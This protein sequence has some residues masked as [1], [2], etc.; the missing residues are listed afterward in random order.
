MTGSGRF[1]TAFD[2][3]LQSG[4]RP[5]KG[6]I[7]ASSIESGNQAW[8]V[9]IDDA[10]NACILVTP[11]PSS[12]KRAPAIALEN[13]EV[14]YRVR[15]KLQHEVGSVETELYTLLR[16]KTEHE[17]DRAVFFSVCE[18]IAKLVGCEPD[19]TALNQAVI[20]LVALFRRLLLPPSRTNIGLF[21]EM[22]FILESR[23][24][25]RAIHAWRNDEYDRYDFSTDKVRIEVKSTSQSQ[26]IHEFSLE[27]CEVLPDVTGMVASV[28]VEPNAGGTTIQQLQSQIENQLTG[29]YSSLLKLRSVVAE[30]LH[31]G[32]NLRS[33]P[34]FDLKK[35]RHSLEIYDLNSIPAIREVPPRGVT[36]VRFKSNLDLCTP[37]RKT[38]LTSKELPGKS[39]LP[40]MR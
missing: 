13:L 39:I 37:L 3:L 17:S 25:G 7:L 16:L 32:S 29:D 30:T 11:K 15:C 8:K 19:E 20:R 40:C 38:E 36:G 2:K 9:G 5:E 22:V 27:Q 6:S 28:I 26:R 24:A 31:S 35:A 18:T 10:G 4:I 12:A 14:Q 21:G 1:L 33:G 23:D 34:A